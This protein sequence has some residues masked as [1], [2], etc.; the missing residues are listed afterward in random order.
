MRV[1]TDVNERQCFD[2]PLEAEHF[3][4]PRFPAGDCLYQVAKQDGQRH[5]LYIPAKRQRG[6]IIFNYL[7]CRTGSLR[8]GAKRR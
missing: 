4:K 6:T 1:L 5:L 2:A 8:V 7:S 3:L